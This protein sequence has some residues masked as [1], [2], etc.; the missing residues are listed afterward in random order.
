M[1]DVG[2]AGQNVF[3]TCLFTDAGKYTTLA[4]TMDPR[5]LRSFMGKYYEALFEP[6]RRRAGIVINVVGDSMLAVWTSPHPNSDFRNRAC[7][8]ALEIS[9]SAEKF[10]QASGAVDLPTRIGLHSGQILLGNVGAEYHYEYRPIG[11]IVNTAS[12][13]E[14]LNKYLGTR[15]LVSSEVLDQLAGFLTREMGAFLLAGKS[16]PVAVHEL[17]CRTG[18][19]SPAES[20]LCE[21]FARGLEAYRRQSWDKAINLF[22]ESLK[23]RAEDGPSAFFLKLSQEHRQNPPGEEW[24]GLVR[25]ENK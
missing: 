7:L 1:A 6:V 2:T 3:G 16:K 8:A 22:Q 4:E 19:C 24:N 13:M 10:N 11:D 25:L 14:G 23:I 5:E 17:V 9:D 21:I 20:E 18:R 12:R 15:I